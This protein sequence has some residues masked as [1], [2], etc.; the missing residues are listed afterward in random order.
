[1]NELLSADHQ[2]FHLTLDEKEARS[3]FGRLKFE[4]FIPLAHSKVVELKVLLNATAA[5]SGNLKLIFMSNYY[6]KVADAPR[7]HSS[8]RFRQPISVVAAS[9]IFPNKRFLIISPNEEAESAC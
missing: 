4:G 3:R 1:M 7:C 6:F 5:K 9:D 2:Q 8:F